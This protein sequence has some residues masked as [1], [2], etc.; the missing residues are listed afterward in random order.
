VVVVT[1]S[2]AA[3][4]A[5]AT[6][7]RVAG[8]LGLRSTATIAIRFGRRLLGKKFFPAVLAAKVKILSVAFGVK[9]S[10]FIHP[11]YADGVFGHINKG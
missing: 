4:L 3:R 8:G 9:R 11:H 10:R 2:I 7:A 6:I 5:A 1:V